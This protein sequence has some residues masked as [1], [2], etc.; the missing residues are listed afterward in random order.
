MLFSPFQFCS[1]VALE[2][3][4][5]ESG[6]PPSLDGSAAARLMEEGRFKYSSPV[7]EASLHRHFTEISPVPGMMPGA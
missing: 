4:V 3:H 7:K 2:S 6:S 5:V 1:S